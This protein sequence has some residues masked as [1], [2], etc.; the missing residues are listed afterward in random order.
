MEAQTVYGITRFIVA[1]GSSLAPIPTWPLVV[2]QAMVVLEAQSRKEP[3]I[4]SGFLRYP[5]PGE[6]QD[7]ITG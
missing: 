5:E 2:L 4:I 6:S 1:W 7:L 3:I